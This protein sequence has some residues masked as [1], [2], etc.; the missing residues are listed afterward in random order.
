MAP[1]LAQT[2]I[3]STILKMEEEHLFVGS[4]VGPSALLK[5]AH[6][7][8]EIEAD[9]D[10]HPALATVVPATSMQ[11]DDEDDDEGICFIFSSLDQPLTSVAQTSMV[12]RK[13]TNQLQ[14]G[15]QMAGALLGRR[16][17]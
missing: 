11:I 4:S 17:Q 1:A 13:Q 7:E 9:V 14:T 6:V 16:A 3:P 5:A 15:Q 12:P 10:V 8:E 2:T